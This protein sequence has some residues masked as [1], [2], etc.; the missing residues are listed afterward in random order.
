MAKTV[1][2]DRTKLKVI[3]DTDIRSSVPANL[4]CYADQNCP[5]KTRGW[6]MYCSIAKECE[7][8]NICGPQPTPGNY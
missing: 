1:C 3:E 2:K 4:E 7:H 6:V 8:R 5:A